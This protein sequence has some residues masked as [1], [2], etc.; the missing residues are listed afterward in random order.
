MFHSLEFKRKNHPEHTQINKYFFKKSEKHDKYG[1]KMVTNGH[2]TSQLS[3]H[4]FE[5]NKNV[6]KYK[7]SP[8]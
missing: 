4:S 1:E 6:F 8:S 3:I 2:F 5:L 7:F